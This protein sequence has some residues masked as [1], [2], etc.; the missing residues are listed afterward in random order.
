MWFVWL[1]SVF[2]PLLLSLKRWGV[3]SYHFTKIHRSVFRKITIDLLYFRD[4][5]DVNLW[6]KNFSGSTSYSC[7]TNIFIQFY[8]FKKRQYKTKQVKQDILNQ[9]ESIVFP[10]LLFWVKKSLR[11]F[12][13]L[14]LG[15]LNHVVS[16]F[17]PKE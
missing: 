4:V 1:F 5:Y 14:S 12:T 8:R 6:V 15:T 3:L 17:L 16:W 7:R 13:K 9:W 2:W 10:K 11:R